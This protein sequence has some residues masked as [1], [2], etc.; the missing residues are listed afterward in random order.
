MTYSQED[1]ARA[2]LRSAIS[3]QN[4]KLDSILTNIL[5]GYYLKKEDGRYGLKTADLDRNVNPYNRTLKTLNDAFFYTWLNKN[6]ASIVSQFYNFTAVPGGGHISRLLKEEKIS[7]EKI[8]NVD[9]L[10]KNILIDFYDSIELQ[11]KKTQE[12]VEKNKITKVDGEALLKDIYSTKIDG[13][14]YKSFF[15][16]FTSDPKELE[17]IE[18]FLNIM[19]SKDSRYKA[20]NYLDTYGMYHYYI[21]R[22]SINNRFIDYLEKNPGASKID[23]VY[24]FNEIVNEQIINHCQ[25]EPT[26]QN[27]FFNRSLMGLN[28]F[29]MTTETAK[30]LTLELSKANPYIL[31]LLS[32]YIKQS[33]KA[34]DGTN[35]IIIKEIEIDGERYKTDDVFF[36]NNKPQLFVNIR[37]GIRNIQHE[38][39]QDKTSFKIVEEDLN[40]NQPLGKAKIISD[41]SKE[42]HRLPPIISTI[43]KR[44]QQEAIRLEKERLEERN[45]GVSQLEILGLDPLG[46][47]TDDK[48]K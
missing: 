39:D 41:T 37:S 13:S 38:N 42:R 7:N 1:Y 46:H 26:S 40:P 11:A 28:S 34:S 45:K 4:R 23:R 15:E 48:I 47:P 32:D 29:K 12:L 25:N 31:E 5:D 19:N 9:P 20:I 22:K 44:E 10:I 24:A 21:F 8:L 36:K 14:D 18:T 2:L 3:T 33:I 27:A 43:R 17:T 16:R 35:K 6:S 30:K